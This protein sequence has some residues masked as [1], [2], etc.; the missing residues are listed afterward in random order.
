MD[1]D[2]TYYFG[3]FTL[4][5]MGGSRIITND[6]LE[7]DNI[8]SLYIIIYIIYTTLRICGSNEGVYCYNVFIFHLGSCDILLFCFI[9]RFILSLNS[10]SEET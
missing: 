3:E 7:N 4:T 1:V 10:Y 2:G 9:F 8:D 5:P 6:K